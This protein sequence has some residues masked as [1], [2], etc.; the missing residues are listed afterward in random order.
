MKAL[1]FADEGGQEWDVTVEDATVPSASSGNVEEGRELV[2]RSPGKP[3]LRVKGY[4]GKLPQHLTRV[5]RLAW[6]GQAEP[7]PSD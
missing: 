7:S 1:H 3:T 5:E 2:F 4:S 6:L